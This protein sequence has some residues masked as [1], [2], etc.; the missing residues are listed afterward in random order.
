MKTKTYG[1]YPARSTLKRTIAIQFFSLSVLSLA[2]VA[3]IAT[4]S[5][6]QLKLSGELVGAAGD[7][8]ALL[9]ELQA[10]EEVEL[11]R[12]TETLKLYVLTR[13]DEQFLAEV[14]KEDGVWKVESV[15]KLRR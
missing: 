14:V 9:D 5:K 8:L 3:G 7:D 6:A 15:E 11:V 13:G 12:E 4:L 2:F 1:K 10:Y